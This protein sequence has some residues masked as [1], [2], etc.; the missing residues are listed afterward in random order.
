MLLVQ[1][2]I[3]ACGQACWADGDVHDSVPEDLLKAEHMLRWDR[4]AEI[5]WGVVSIVLD[6][7]A[8]APG[9]RGTRS[10]L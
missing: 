2:V 7:Q 5:T 10:H 4:G 9:D 3:V 6:T 1:A 8:G